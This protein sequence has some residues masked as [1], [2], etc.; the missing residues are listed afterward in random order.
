MIDFINFMYGLG[1]ISF[2][3]FYAYFLVLFGFPLSFY[4]TVV[5]GGDK[6]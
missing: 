4:V 3:E 1:Q 6:K 5:L 2:V